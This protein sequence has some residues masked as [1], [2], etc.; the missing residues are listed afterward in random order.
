MQCGERRS[1]DVPRVH[2]EEVAQR[3][4]I[5]AAAEAIRTQRDHRRPTHRE[6]MSGWLFR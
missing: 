5:L 2:F 4:S 1:R 3:L 6:I